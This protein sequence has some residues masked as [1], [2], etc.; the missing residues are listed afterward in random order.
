MLLWALA[1]LGHTPPPR[2]LQRVAA[3]TTQRLSEQKQQQQ[4]QQDHT[5]R[6][7]GRAYE[8]GA[9]QGTF[10]GSG[11]GPLHLR[12]FSAQALANTAWAFARLGHHPGEGWMAEAAAA[13]LPLLQVCCHCH[14]GP[15]HCLYTTQPS[16]D[17]VLVMRSTVL[18]AV[19]EQLSH[20]ACAAA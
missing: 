5:H 18:C 7:W 2:L 8:P 11:Y 9:T 19:R 17:E 13:S 12:A 15:Y 1:T 6:Q 20:A 3:L 4:Q 16:K 14:A 10:A